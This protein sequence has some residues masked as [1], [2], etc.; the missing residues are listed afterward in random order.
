MKC[1]IIKNG[2]FFVGASL[3]LG[4]W[5]QLRLVDNGL[6]VPSGKDR[7]K[8]GVT[9]FNS[10]PF[11]V[12][13]YPIVKPMTWGQLQKK[14]GLPDDQLRD[15]FRCTIKRAAPSDIAKLRKAFI[16]GKGVKLALKPD[17]CPD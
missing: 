1:N 9:S 8:I 12:M 4:G 3:V 15:T 14:F 17:A 16:N 6:D 2:I 5:F 10:N 13:E 7:I 11:Y